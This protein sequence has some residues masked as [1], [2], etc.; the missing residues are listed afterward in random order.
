M[1]NQQ[2]NMQNILNKI[3]VYRSKS[4]MIMES[5]VSVQ[6]STASPMVQFKFASRADAKSAGNWNNNQNAYWFPSFASLVE[7]VSQMAML[8]GAEAGNANAIASF[9]NPMKQK[10]LNL[11]KNKDDNN[12]IWYMFSYVSGSADSGN[13]VKINSSCTPTEFAGIYGYLKNLLTQWATVAQ[14]A[15]MRYDNWFQTV[16]KNK[17]N[18]QNQQGGGNGGGN[19]GNQQ[20]GGSNYSNQN[21]Q[22]GN[23]QG[24][25]YQQK[26]QTTQQN[27]QQGGVDPNMM[28][29]IN[30]E[31]GNGSINP[32]DDIPF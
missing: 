14:M 17:L 4:I 9:K 5:Q 11:R 22:G 1:A 25:G 30:N 15:L 2:V 3:E 28:N 23:Q 16:G 6:Y 13:Q 24:G 18:S 27:T 26:P 31:F 12:N 10:Y 7:A 21:Q 32:D 29:D 19:G 20:G 8:N